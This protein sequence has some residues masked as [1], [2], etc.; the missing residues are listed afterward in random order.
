VRAGQP[1]WANITATRAQTAAGWTT[2]T[3]VKKRSKK[4][5]LDQRRILFARRW[6]ASLAECLNVVFELLFLVV[7]QK[8]VVFDGLAFRRGDA[9]PSPAESGP[10]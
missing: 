10:A 3:N 4:R 1:L 7:I 6:Q 2:V 5:P 8:S 9:S